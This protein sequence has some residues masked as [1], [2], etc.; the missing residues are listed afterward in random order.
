VGEVDLFRSLQLLPGVSGTNDATSGLYVRGGTP[1]QNLV[2]LDGMTVYHVDHFFGIFSAFNTDAIQ[3]MR[4]YKGGFPAKYGGRTSSVVELI[5]KTGDDQEFRASGGVNLLSARGVIEVPLGHLGSWLISGRRSYTDLLKTPLYNRLFNTISS[6][7]QAQ[8]T[9]GGVGPGGNQRGGG[10]VSQTLTPSYY[11]DDLNSKLTLHPTGRDIFAFSVYQGEDHLDQSS[12]GSTLS[13]GS[14]FP[15][16]GGFPGGSFQ[17]PSID[18]LTSWGNAGASAHWSR[19]WGTRFT[20]DLLAAGSSYHSNSNNNSSS[21]N[22]SSAFIE[23]NQVDD[24]TLRL[25]N[26]WQLAQRI[27]AAFGFWLT[28]NDVSYG[29]QR[30]LTDTTTQSILARSANAKQLAGYLQSDWEALRGLDLTA[31]VRATNYDLRHESLL[32]PRLSATYALDGHLTLKGAWGRYHQFVNRVENQDILNGS[33]DFW[34]LADST[35]P[36]SAAEHRIAG[37]AYETPIWL[38]DVEGYWKKTDDVAEFSTRFRSVPVGGG[39]DVVDPSTAGDANSFFFLGSSLA[40]GV[41]LLA[42][43]KEGRLTGWLSYTLGR[44]RNT[45]PDL[46][47]GQPFP[48]T[49]DQTHEVKAVADLQLGLWT[50]SG[51]AVYGSGQAYTAPESRYTL[52]LLDGAT[53]SYIHVGAMNGARLPAYQRVDLAV[54][55]RFKLGGY[56]MDANASVINALNHRNVWYRRFD[57]SQNP[58]VVTDVTTLGFTP[59]LGLSFS[60]K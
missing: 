12:S 5:G 15:G 26:D 24:L 38:F 17:T 43:K 60:R 7:T 3:D 55:R 8:A 56:V 37:V 4:L 10:F 1:D 35:L 9:P 46:N 27:K 53:E 49:Y 44:V 51:L 30:K 39:F 42:Q 32:E 52:T 34:L 59:S 28:K 6:S 40:R 14:G 58:M 41:E 31:G 2:L 36:S 45:F 48:A 25:D 33:R 50:F 18:N 19:Q 13:G 11:F 21:T 16:G 20:S 22:N 57:L 54:T 47:N 29:Y 23:K